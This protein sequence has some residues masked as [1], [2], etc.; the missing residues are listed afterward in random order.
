MVGIGKKKAFCSNLLLT[1]FSEPSQELL[2]SR[3]VLEIG[4]HLS[5]EQKDDASFERF[6]AQLKTYYV[7]YAAV[8]PE[9]AYQ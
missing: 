1:H 7:D 9:S 5:I 8:L 2:L 3:D 4:A 6:I